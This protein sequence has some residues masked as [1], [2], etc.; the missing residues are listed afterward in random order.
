MQLFSAGFGYMWGG[1]RATHGAT[2]GKVC[3]EVKID[4]NQPT[5]H[6]ENESKPNLLRCGW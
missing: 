6:L 5:S 2:R 1:V 3:F 4:G